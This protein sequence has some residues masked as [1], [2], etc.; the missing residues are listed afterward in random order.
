MSRRLGGLLP[1]LLLAALVVAS[2]L[3]ARHWQGGQVDYRRLNAQAGCVLED[4]RCRQP[5]AGG[6]VSFS[7]DPPQIPL[8]QTLTLSVVLDGIQASAVTVDLRG[9]NMD[10][11]LNRTA[12][13][14]AGDGSWRGETII[15]ICT[16]RRMEWEAAV[17][18]DAAEPVEVAF[19]FSTLRD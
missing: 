13:V 7:I 17:R 5:V 12:L 14:P 16:L 10:M 11:G 2:F 15:P 9:L 6:A 18:L 19:R 1:V 3:L 4:G 8:M